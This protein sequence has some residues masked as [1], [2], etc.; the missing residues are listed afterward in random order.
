MKHV[1]IYRDESRYA[2]H[3]SVC[4]IG[5]GDVLV[6]FRDAPFEHIF[7]HV[8]PRATAGLV[9]SSDLGE[10]WGPKSTVIDLGAGMNLNDPSITALRDGTLLV[11]AFATPAPYEKDKNKWGDRAK[12]VRGTDYYYVGAERKIW[13]T[14]SFDQGVT[15]EEPREVNTSACGEGNAGVFANIVEMGDGTLLMPITDRL[16]DARKVGMLIASRDRGQTWE[17]YS[18][19]VSWQSEDA[20]APTF[21][22]PS[23]LAYDDREMLAVGWTVAEHGTLVTRSSDAGMTWS[24]VERVD[25]R[26]ACMHLCVTKS[27]ATLMSY[28]Y[29]HE[30]YGITVLPSYNRGKTWDMNL[31]VSLRSDGAMRD[32]GYPWTTQLSDGRLLCVYYFNVHEEEKKYYDEEQTLKICEQWNLDPALYAYSVA[33]LRFIGGTF[34]TEEEL[35]DLAGTGRPEEEAAREE[36]TL[37]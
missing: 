11:T 32:I 35:R 37:L 17:P 19:I 1:T 28:G 2:S 13:L 31:A 29:R 12:A 16:S 34:F 5:N 21:G 18:E 36:P 6:A 24:P 14:R 20:N 33:G 30:P 7:A 4:Q 9:K 26:G 27:G 3:A 23:V 10:T 15:W 22:L 25:T 8:H